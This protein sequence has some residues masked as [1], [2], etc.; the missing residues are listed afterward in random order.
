MRVRAMGLV[1]LALFGC[2][3]EDDP[4]DKT[5]AA[6]DPNTW[7]EADSP[8]QLDEDW[9]VEAGDTLTIEPGVTVMLADDVNIIVH[10]ELLA[11]GTSET[12]IT[13]TRVD[14]GT[15]GEGYI[16][17]LWGSIHFE[18]DAVD[19]S[20]VDVDDYEAGSIIEHAVIEYGQRAVKLSS[21]APYIVSSTFR[22]NK[23][24]GD[25]DTI[26]GAAL[27]MNDGSNARVRD[28]TFE[29]NIAEIFAF[30]GAIYAHHSD[31]ILQDNTFIDNESTYGGALA[32]DLMASPIVG[33]T[34]QGN[35]TMSEGGALSVV[36]TI[37]PI[38]NNQITNNHADKD[39]GGLHVC[40]T[41][42]PHSAPFVMDNVVTGNTTADDPEHGA[43]GVGA[44][45]LKVLRDN[46]IQDNT[47]P[48]GASDFGWFHE[49]SEG[50]PAWVSHPSIAE[51][52]WGSTDPTFIAETIH[53][54]V[55]DP[56]LG[57]VTWDPVLEAEPTGPIT[58]V[59]I[60]SRKLTYVDNGDDMSVFL[61]LYNPGPERS[62]HLDIAL[63]AGSV[64]APWAGELDFPGATAA[65]GGW[66]LTLPENSVFFTK[67][68]EGDYSGD[69]GTGGGY[70]SAAISDA[71]NSAPIGIESISPFDYSSP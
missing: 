38:L 49:L 23:I 19:A 37:S 35:S 68:Q 3:K 33:N 57:S 22:D 21:A 43:A 1:A 16:G 29:R 39:G 8:I 30:G 46:V 54:G 32:T 9:I 64:P 34:W 26:G 65:G 44:A 42:Y 66:D 61:T 18:D 14:G 69:D 56:A 5:P 36:S 25:V 41:C 20:F 7:T 52:W 50:Y 27:Q 53:D 24:P 58:R 63:A 4:A 28:C 71:A 13:F 51:N 15:L 12:P 17:T 67:L 62:I 48:A 31:P 70:W 6:D 60:T 47:G 10:G 45:Y 40:V 59:T 11:R 55:D 2:N